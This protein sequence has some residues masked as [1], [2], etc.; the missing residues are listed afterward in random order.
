MSSEEIDSW[1][2]DRAKERMDEAY[3][4]DGTLGWFAAAARELE[5]ENQLDIR[6]RANLDQ[7]AST[8]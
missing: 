6:R 5:I 3:E 2:W 4:R 8:T 1:T 7:T